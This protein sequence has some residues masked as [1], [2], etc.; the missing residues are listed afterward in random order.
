MNRF[1]ALYGNTDR[2][3]S[4]HSMSV[5]IMSR[6]ILHLHKTAAQGLYAN[7]EQTIALHG[8]RED[9]S[10]TLSITPHNRNAPIA[11]AVTFTTLWSTMH[12]PITTQSSNIAGPSSGAESPEA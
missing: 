4:G 2:G 10:S 3:V 1:F 6:L 7:H 9:Y 12:V 5:T 8:H 11:S